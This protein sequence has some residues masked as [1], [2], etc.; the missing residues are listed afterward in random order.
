MHLD[1]TAVNW[2]A[3]VIAAVVG[4]VIAL[5]WYAPQV[6][7]RHWAAAA[8]VELLAPSQAPPITIALAV[9]TVLVTAYALA[10][11]ARAVGAASIVDGAILGFVAWLGFVATWTISAVTFEHKPWAYWYLN[12]GQGLVALV[13]M[14]AVIGYLK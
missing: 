2:L 14:G 12:A 11:L 8:G 3:V 13:V 1:F 5:I 10:L 9:V 7:G 6:F 4:A